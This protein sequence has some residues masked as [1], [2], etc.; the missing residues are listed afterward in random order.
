MSVHFPTPVAYKL[1]NLIY[2]LLSAELQSLYNWPEL[3]NISAFDYIDYW[4]T[5]VS[6]FPIDLKAFETENITKR[7]SKAVMFGLEQLFV[8]NSVLACL[9][10]L[11][12]N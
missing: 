7:F 5:Y 8:R 12:P 3:T 11:Y 10:R 9:F 2:S 4:V 1:Y 6:M